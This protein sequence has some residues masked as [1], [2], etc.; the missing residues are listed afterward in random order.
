[1][2]TNTK[3][4][5]I[6]KPGSKSI[7]NVKV[8]LSDEQLKVL[9][10]MA[11]DDEHDYLESYYEMADGDYMVEMDP[12]HDLGLGADLNDVLS[13]GFLLLRHISE[14]A[15]TKLSVNDVALHPFRIKVAQIINVGYTLENC[16]IE[17]AY[18]P[19]TTALDDNGNEISL[20]VTSIGEG[21]E[22]A[23]CET[24]WNDDFWCKDRPNCCLNCCPC[25]FGMNCPS[26][27]P[28][29]DEPVSHDN[30]KSNDLPF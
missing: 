29:Q 22:C 18:M 28:V 3:T 14:D 10:E 1:M 20:D 7:F 12:C 21:K 19:I 24:V 17:S 4:P 5:L 23:V 8:A 25:A 15:K 27:V 26:D 16:K 2:D 11:G 13:L 9:C 6:I 30:D